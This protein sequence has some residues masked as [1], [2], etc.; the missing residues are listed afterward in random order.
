MAGSLT[1]SQIAD[2]ENGT[3]T[4][5]V[6]NTQGIPILDA[7][8]H[9]QVTTYHFAGASAVATLETESQ[10]STLAEGQGF[11][12][13]GPGQFNVTAASLDLGYSPGILSYGFGGPYSSLL[14][15]AGTLASG[16]AAVNVTV[17][18]NINLI[19][20]A[21]AS[22]DGGNVNVHAGGQMDLSQGTFDFANSACY[23]IYTSGHSDVSVTAGSDINV[24]SGCIAS[25]NGGNVFVESYTGSVNAGNGANKAL[26]VNGVYL[27]ANGLPVFAE[28][29][30]L[31]DVSSLKVNPAPYGSGI[32][33]EYPTLKYQTPGGSGQPGNITVL[34]PKGNI[35]SS[36]GGI[37]QFALNGSIAGGP[38]V[39][40]EAGTVGVA[41]TPDQGNIILGAGGVVGGTVNLTAQGNIQGL[42]VSR[43]NANVSAQQNVGITLLSGGN[44][45]VSSGGSTSGTIVGIGS[46][47]VSG[48]GGVTAALL[49]QNVSVG[50]GAAISTLGTSSGATASSQA[51]AQQSSQADTQQ[52]AS[53]NS[54]DDNKN[55]KKPVIRKVSRVTVLLSSAV[56]AR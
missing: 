2:L 46:V 49:G 11:L 16:G 15:V 34:T 9:L 53:G 3:F 50:G 7:N 4:V 30:E 38:V 14:D 43:Q 37:S 47:N 51:A 8:G 25:F 27:D 13:G 52:V 29:G 22:Q 12:I 26:Y 1:A 42:I 32:L 20:S 31:T 33:A 6:A 19:T 54:E 56:P 55:K 39:T 41:A 10:N 36:R 5:I 45:N 18:G 24:G 48:A 23:G 40:L 17:G 21:I 44:A 28:Y 35:V